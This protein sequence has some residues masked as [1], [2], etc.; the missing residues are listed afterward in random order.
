MGCTGSSESTLVKIPHCWKSLVTAQILFQVV[1]VTMEQLVA[2][3]MVKLMVQLSP[4]VVV[5][6]ATKLLSA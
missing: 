5:E 1:Q 2:P 3:L 4:L 6:V